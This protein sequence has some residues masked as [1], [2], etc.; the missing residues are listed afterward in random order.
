MKIVRHLDRLAVRHETVFGVVE[1]HDLFHA[2]DADI[3][4]A[5]FFGERFGVVPAAR[6]ERLAVRPQHRRHLGIGDAGGLAAGVDYA[7]AQPGTL[8]GQ[9]QEMAAVRLDVQRGDAA[10]RFVG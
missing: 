1:A 4:R 3:E 7:R 10:E 9:R 5:V 6:G 2:L 8:V